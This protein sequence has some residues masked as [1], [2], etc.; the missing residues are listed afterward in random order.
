MRGKVSTHCPLLIAD[1][2]M[3]SP[4]SEI[5]IVPEK[6]VA[7]G[8]M[9]ARHE[10]RVVLVR[11][12]I[13]GERVR[14]RIERTSRDVAHAVAVDIL[15]PHADR[16]EPPIDAGCG[17][18]AFAH[19]AYRRQLALKTEIVSDA[20]ARIARMTVPAPVPIAS[21]PE[22]GYRMRARLHVQG[23]RAGF[24]REGTH[25][26]CDPATS[27]QLQPEATEAIQHIARTLYAGGAGSA[28]VL[29][30]ELAENIAADQR[31]VHVEFRDDPSSWLTGLD[32][33]EGLTG[34]SWSH[35]A[36][37]RTHVVTGSPYVTDGL[38]IRPLGQQATDSERRSTSEVGPV[39]VHRHVRAFFQA[40]RYLLSELVERVLFRVPEGPVV[41]LYAGVG[42][43]AVALAS[44]RRE[45]V[46]AVE[47]D[48]I[49]AHDLTANAA[50]CERPF[51]AHHLSVEQYLRESPRVPL[52]TVVLDPPRTGL[53]KETA[54]SLLRHQPR[55][56]VY[57]S[58]DVATLARDVRVLT[59]AGYELTW[60]EAFDLFP[61]TAHIETLAVLTR[62]QGA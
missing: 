30:I 1:A 57:V 8:S 29:G 9:L 39:R 15:E 16:R 40:N 41:D 48:A 43:F 11:G 58:C 23:S 55:R 18:N 56:L 61:N 62:G 28:V 22:R 7:G 51:A 19:I 12:A 49:S 31:A 38:D 53:S 45:D 3:L 54:A 10:G 47:G 21:S 34:L 14:V 52:R 32:A 20:F 42:L 46:V 26:L 36:D 33:I 27:G 50:A 5:E 17:G 44:T 37:P 24:Y 59:E 60:L 6:P 4:G 25:E 13:P 35:A 2:D